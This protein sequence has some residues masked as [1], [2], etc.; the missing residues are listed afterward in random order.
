LFDEQMTEKDI[1]EGL[2]LRRLMEHEDY[3]PA[4]ERLVKLIEDDAVKQ[5]C[6]DEGKSKKWLK[7]AR[8]TAQALIPAIQARAEAAA[9]ALEERKELEQSTRS[10]S[11]DG[12]GSG[13]L[14][15]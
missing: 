6:D 8:E 14:A 5:F 13:D 2:V 3:W 10:V 12:T 7:G 11:D 1:D 15:L 4:L 9:G